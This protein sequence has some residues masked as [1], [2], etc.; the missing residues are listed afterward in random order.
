[1]LSCLP[2]NG[3]RVYAAALA[4][5]A[6]MVGCAQAIPDEP[7]QIVQLP[8]ARVPDAE[9]DERGVIHVAY[10]AGHDVF[11]VQSTDE[12]TRFSDPIRV[13]SEPGFASGGLFRGPDLALGQGGRVHV[14]WYNNAYAEQRPEEDWGLMYARLN[15][16][17]TGFEPRRNLNQRR[18]DNYSLAADTAGNVAAIW[19][20]EDLFVSLSGDGGT[21]F[22]PPV[23]LDAD[24]C[25]CC[26][27]RA[28]YAPGGDL[29]VVY[30]DKA[31]NERDMY[32]GRIRQD[33]AP[34]PPV[35]L[36]ADTWHL[37]AC[38]L[39][40]TFLTGD[41]ER[42]LVAW[43]LKGHVYFA[44]LDHEGHMLDP[45][46]VQVSESGKYPVVLRNASDIL[47]AW[48]DGSRLTWQRFDVQGRP[49]G[50]RRSI[51]SNTRDRPAGVVTKSGMFLLFP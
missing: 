51:K 14:A 10:L 19:T 38:P 42:L 35:K 31:R 20:T 27:S 13:N 32:L 25:E 50:E 40:G 18:S 16:T 7:V 21:T 11:Y 43:E 15:D 46:E 3:K 29:Y 47:V 8:D 4:V 28:W 36:N 26:A 44:R 49:R 22:A 39:S 24:P 12:G 45:G 48:K 6:L 37:N 30:R 5:A 34:F 2:S 9:I 1:M 41:E 23:R 17:H 33:A